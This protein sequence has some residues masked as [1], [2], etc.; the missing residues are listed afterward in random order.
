MT[1]RIAVLFDAENV[2]CDTARL[3]LGRLKQ[4]GQVTVRKAIGDFSLP[5]LRCWADCGRALALDLEMQV[6]LG[7]GKN[8]AD[9]RLAIEAMDIAHARVVDTIA[10]VTQDG[11]FTPL[12]NRLR[13]GGMTVLGFSQS[14]P[15][16][17]FRQ[18]CSAFE[19]VGPVE[20]VVVPVAKSVEKLRPD[21]LA[22]LRRIINEA[23][24]G[25]PITPQ[26]LDRATQA[27][28]TLHKRI[29]AQGRHLKTL[30]SYGLVE[31][32]GEGKNLRVRPPQLKVAS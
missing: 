5:A 6:S 27:N 13:A 19:Q 30:V 8:G 9:M 16:E 22:E 26:A 23:C 28:G 10:L 15:H 2:N 11:D 20:P 12:A 24:K 3:V 1:T 17:A 31:R 7:K 32:I 21:E 14:K 29:L 18:A 4:K 25:G